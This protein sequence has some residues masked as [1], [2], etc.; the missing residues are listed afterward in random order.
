MNE[1]INSIILSMLPISEIRGGIP[2][3]LANGVSFTNAFI[4]LTLA[5][6]L[7]VPI[8]FIFLDTLNSQ[9]MK[10]K[11]Y[12]Y[13]FNKWVNR[14][15][16]KIEHRIGTAWE[17]PTLFL[18]V[19]IPFPLTGAYTGTLA[20][21]LFNVNRTKAILTIAFGVFIA[22]LIVSLIYFGFTSF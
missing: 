5:N 9:F 19:A 22:A 13:F 15:R 20:A 10:I 3:A 8:F 14:T 17:L 21:W 12:N 16:K 18:F 11:P 7:I 1:L 6:I 4:L 2:Y